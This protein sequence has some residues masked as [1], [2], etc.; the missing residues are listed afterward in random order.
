MSFN[1]SEAA[2]TSQTTSCLRS[3][4]LPTNGAKRPNTQIPDGS[5][6]APKPH[7]VPNSPEIPTLRTNA[8]APTDDLL[9]R[10]HETHETNQRTRLRS[11]KESAE[12]ASGNG[13]TTAQK[14]R[15]PYDP[16]PV[17]QRDL[18]LLV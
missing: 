8:A 11:R 10:L 15:S 17:T 5:D 14:A 7:S 12:S 9:Q 6:A 18:D 4:S 3:P 1:I 16:K 2:N 13:S